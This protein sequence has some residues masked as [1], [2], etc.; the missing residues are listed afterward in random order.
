[1]S[2]DQIVAVFSALVSF[3]GLVFVAMQMRDA[4]KQRRIESVQRLIDANREL[5]SLAFSHPNLLDILNDTGK[6]DPQWE[7]RYLQL[8]LNQLMMVHTMLE[9]RGFDPDYREGLERDIADT[10]A[11]DN[12]QRHWM[13]V[14]YA[15]SKSFQKRVNAAIAKLNGL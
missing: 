13:R 15:Y 11:S 9:H 12:M 4:T 6:A 10:L 14:S 2:V 7:L 3:A 5:L 8:W 1:M